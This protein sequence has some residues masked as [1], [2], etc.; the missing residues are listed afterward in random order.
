MKLRCKDD[1]QYET[2]VVADKI[3]VVMRDLF[4]YSWGALLEE[5]KP[6]KLKQPPN[7]ADYASWE[8][9]NEGTE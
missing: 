4:P 5:H 2:R 3:S 7:L 9:W 8:Y 6:A 1:T